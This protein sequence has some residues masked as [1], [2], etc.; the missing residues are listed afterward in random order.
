MILRETAIK[1][2]AGGQEFCT[3]RKCAFL[4]ALSV[5]ALV[6]PV[7]A[8]EPLK[9][10]PPEKKPPDVLAEFKVDKGR[11]AIFLPVRIQGKEYLFMLDTG[12]TLCIFDVSFKELLGKPVKTRDVDTFGGTK[13]LAW[14]NPPEAYLGKLDLREGGLV[15]CTDFEVIRRV[16]GR[17]VSGFVGMGFLK[18]YV[19][20]IDFDSGV[21]Q[22]R[23]WD[24]RRHPEWGSP[25]FLY[26]AGEERTDV[27]FVKGNLAGVGDVELL[28]DSGYSGSGC[29]V[30]Q[31]F[32]KALNKSALAETLGATIVD[33]HRSRVTRISNLRLGGF[34]HRDLALDEENQNAIGLGLLSRYVVTF[35]FPSMKMYLQKGKA[36]DKPDEIDMSGLHL[37]RLGGRTTVHSVDKDSPAEAAGIKPE[38]VVLKVG[39]QSASVMDLENL[40]DLL[41]SGDGK[42][43][44]LTIKRGEKEQ[45]V[46]FNLKRRM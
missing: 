40:R 39:E 44:K 42:E 21:V 43:I 46:S 17:E 36:F 23:R 3:N 35:D 30:A 38:D 16:F 26:D 19:V 7:L 2:A 22:F 33:T 15:L 20:R 41:K 45:F 13:A 37:W 9:E 10:P 12:A 6:L 4:A 27:P 11:R 29:L 32:G 1:V 28:V 25:V 34:D 24:G 31:V 18:H 14:F 5:Y 8:A